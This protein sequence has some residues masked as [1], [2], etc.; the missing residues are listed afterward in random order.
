MPDVCQEFYTVAIN[1][2]ILTTIAGIVAVSIVAFF[3]IPHWTAVL[4]VSPLITTLYI[5][6]LGT[7][8][9]AGLSIHPLT[10]MCLVISIGL[11][12]DFVLHLILRYYESTAS[13]RDGHHPAGPH[14]CPWTLRC[15]HADR[16]VGGVGG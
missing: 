9:L 12:I 8:Q 6:L 15:R 16:A 13:T 11:L 2:L 14:Y 5:D 7:L 10:Y 3:F 4:F 1:E